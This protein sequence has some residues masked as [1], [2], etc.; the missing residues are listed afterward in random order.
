MTTLVELRPVRRWIR[1]TQASH[2]ERGE[3][4]GTAYTIVFCVGVAAAMFHEPLEAVFTPLV[5]HLSGVGALAAAT[6]C[7]ALLF[8]ALRRLGPVT[9][10]RPAAYFLLTA[11][12]SRRL[13]LAPALHT[14]ATGTALAAAAITFAVLGHAAA[15]GSAVLVVTG[16]LAGV[17]LTLLASAAQ[18]RPHLAAPADGVARLALAL[19]LAALV[20]EATGWTPPTIGGTPATSVVLP[21]TGALAVLATAAYLSAVRDIARTPSAAILESAKTTGTLADSVYG[22]EP[23]FVADMLERRYWS[24]RRLRSTTLHRRLPPLTAQDLLLARRRT[25][26]LL[27]TAASTALPLLLTGAPN[28]LLALTLVLGS[29]LAARATTATVK[30][31]A[32]NPVLLRLLGL[33]SRQAVRQR[34]WLPAVLAT[35]WA[36]VSLA[37]LQLSGALPPGQ[38]WLL[39]LS[40]GPI[41]AISALRA[42]RSG[43][44]RNDLIPID[45]PMGS[46]ATGPLL[47]AFIGIDLLLLA[48][49][50]GIQLA[51]SL[52]AAFDMILVQTAIAIAGAQA[53]LNLTTDPGRLELSARRR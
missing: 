32:A 6:V 8:L 12:V 23:S 3:A 9:V 30:I 49:P 2:R 46:L 4:L 33:D 13:L 35:S 1:R 38:W 45:T 20:A 42:A 39:G 48:L 7:A 51:Q 24:R 15:S 27:W 28:W 31:D 52:P 41:G 47:H 21:L 53:Y 40:L 26:R 50:T 17:L 29:A 44:V 22:M 11:P 5:P 19:G 10:S 37:L 34:F 14:T 25:P 36:T 16:A 18:R 43:M